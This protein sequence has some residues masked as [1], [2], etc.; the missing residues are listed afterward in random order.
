VLLFNR[1]K[2]AA[3]STDMESKRKGYLDIQRYLQLSSPDSAWWPLGYDLYVELAKATAQKAISKEELSRR[4][5]GR[6]RVL[7]TLDLAKDKQI[8]LSEATPDV[9]KRLGQDTN[10]GIPVF[11]SSIYKR[12]N[13]VSAGIDIL[14]GPKV[15]AIFL[16]GDKAPPIIIQGKGLGAEKAELR[17]G[18]TVK[19]LLSKF[20]SEAVETNR[21]IDNPAVKYV[22]LPDL[23]LAIRAANDR[24]AEMVLVQIPRRGK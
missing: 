20:K 22:F 24:I 9:L 19:D 14:G 10:K 6:L 7:T 21:S 12:Y 5:I 2:M 4:T 23:G 3:T 11:E 1:A 16:T 17:V 13:A 15:M 8:T 18:M